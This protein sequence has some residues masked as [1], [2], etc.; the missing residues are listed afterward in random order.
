MGICDQHKI[1]K[2]RS[3]DGRGKG[4]GDG[5]DEEKVVGA[6]SDYL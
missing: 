6:S 2:Q 4:G 1:C 3:K 5:G